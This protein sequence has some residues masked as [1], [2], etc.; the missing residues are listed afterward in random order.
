MPPNHVE[1]NIIFPTPTHCYVT[2]LLYVFVVI[3]LHNMNVQ[4]YVLFTKKY[5]HGIYLS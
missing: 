2:I 5:C 4:I 1:E 3:C